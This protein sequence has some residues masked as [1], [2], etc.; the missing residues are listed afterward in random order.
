[1]GIAAET[2]SVVEAKGLLPSQFDI[3]W[4]LLARLEASAFPACE[5]NIA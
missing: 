4:Y 5:A 3:S 2:L 1:M